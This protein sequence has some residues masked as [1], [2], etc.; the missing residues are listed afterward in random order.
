MTMTAEQFDATFAAL[1]DP[2]RR[3]IVAR[4]ARS[5][6][7]VNEL[8]APFS[9]SLPGIS[10]HLK[11]LERSGLISR[12]KYAQFRPCHLERAA[13]EAAGGWIEENRRI[14]SERFD[15]L[16]EHLRDIGSRRDREEGE[17]HD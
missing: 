9:M 12:T 8:A 15:K 17:L 4:L 3:A 13:L 1:A 11:V 6:A 14:W 2:T 5:D 10:K 16:D 7:T